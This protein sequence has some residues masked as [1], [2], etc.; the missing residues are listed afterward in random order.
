MSASFAKAVMPRIRQEGEPDV[1]L[2]W[3]M[4]WSFEIRT[5]RPP[6]AGHEPDRPGKQVARGNNPTP[7]KPDESLTKNVHD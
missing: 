1:E 4:G 5:D 7:K 2:E 6:A 3:K